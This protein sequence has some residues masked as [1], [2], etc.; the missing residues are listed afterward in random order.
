TLQVP[1]PRTEIPEA[2]IPVAS[3]PRYFRRAIELRERFKS[4]SNVTKEMVLWADLLTKIES[5]EQ[6]REKI[7]WTSA[8][9]IKRALRK[10]AKEARALKAQPETSG[11]SYTLL[12]SSFGQRFEQIRSDLAEQ[13]IVL[14]PDSDNPHPSPEHVVLGFALHLADIVASPP[15][16]S[17]V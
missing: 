16:R 14:D 1:V 5:D 10:L 4:L 13:R 2:L 17:I 7:G 3:I 15:P 12:Q 11:D 8:A 9:D 6:V